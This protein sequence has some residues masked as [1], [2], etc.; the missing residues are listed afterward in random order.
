LANYP[1]SKVATGAFAGIQTMSSRAG[2]IFNK[3]TFDV[4]LTNPFANTL[5]TSNQGDQFFVTNCTTPGRQIATEEKIIHGPAYNI[6]YANVFSGDFE[7]TCIYSQI[8]HRFITDWMDKIIPSAAPTLNFLSWQAPERPVYY[9]DLKR[10]SIRID[11][12]SNNL[13]SITRY[14]LNECF[15]KTLNGLDLDAGSQNSYQNISCSFAFRDFTIEII[16][17]TKVMQKNN[18]NEDETYRGV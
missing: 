13:Q 7:I 1:T 10:G 18:A 9:D 6:P 12:Y 15:P 17:D 8:T 5:T 4:T 11:Y 14:T 16:K 3:H 2:S